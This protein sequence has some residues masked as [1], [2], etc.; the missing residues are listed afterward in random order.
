M[1]DRN[2]IIKA[3]L[4]QIHVPAN[5]KKKMRVKA[6]YDKYR[7]SKLEQLMSIFC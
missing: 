4:G 2:K 6:K 7:N 3:A 1:E 5:I